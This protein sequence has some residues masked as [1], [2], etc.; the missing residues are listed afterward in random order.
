MRDG[1]KNKKVVYQYDLEGN[2]L[3]EFCSTHNAGRN[4]STNPN[5]YK[6]ISACALGN[7]CSAHTFR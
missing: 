2:Y 4:V 1:A 7:M 3:N 6:S 5:A